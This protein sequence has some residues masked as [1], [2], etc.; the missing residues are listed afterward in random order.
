MHLSIEYFVFF[1]L[2][3]SFHQFWFEAI[4]VALLQTV[5]G[6]QRKNKSSPFPLLWPG[7]FCTASFSVKLKFLT[8]EYNE[9]R[10]KFILLL[11][12]MYYF[13]LFGSFRVYCAK[14][15]SGKTEIVNAEERKNLNAKNKIRE[16]CAVTPKSVTKEVIC[17]DDE[18]P[19]LHSHSL[20]TVPFV[21]P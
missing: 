2:V 5:K 19:L 1:S 20:R 12:F 8:G 16:I 14:W 18:M 15:F 10:C 4:S 11:C 7:N 13:F 3:S 21:Y 17:Y 9:I 6:E